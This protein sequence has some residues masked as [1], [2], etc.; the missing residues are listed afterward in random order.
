M[1]LSKQVANGSDSGLS[2]F[3]SSDDNDKEARDYMS[4]YIPVKGLVAGLPLICI[5][6]GA[7][8]H[9]AVGRAHIY[10]SIIR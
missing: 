6:G 10:D 3:D 1:I 5:K 7:L 8:G 4:R 2:D 9:K